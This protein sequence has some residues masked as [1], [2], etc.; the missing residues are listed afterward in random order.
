MDNTPLPPV[1][2]TRRLR[3][4]PPRPDDAGDAFA[5]FSDPEVTRYWSFPAWHAP[6][7]AVR[8]LE[9]RRALA[10]PHAF[11]WAVAGVDDDR[12][13]GTT[14]LF[15]PAGREARAEVG[16]ALARSAQGQG[17]GAEMV[18]AALGFGFGT[19]RLARVEAEVDPENTASARLLGR[20]GFVVAGTAP[21]RWRVD[22]RFVDRLVLH[23]HA[24]RFRAA[25]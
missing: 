25:A 22:G 5:L 17:F 10:P 9:S 6:A 3:L 15:V 7:Q 20:L 2:A 21:A 13:I 19:L 11:E 18:G 23:L 16:F 14:T 4:R 12:M 1:L 24:D 8:W